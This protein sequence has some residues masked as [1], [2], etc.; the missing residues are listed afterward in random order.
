MRGKVSVKKVTK[1]TKFV[2][3]FG[4][5]RK[6]KLDKK[7]D[8]LWFFSIIFC[9]GIAI[10]SAVSVENLNFIPL[11]LNFRFLPAMTTKNAFFLFSISGEV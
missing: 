5:L 2:T 6:K 1:V 8:S 9:W 11:I 7:G 4:R 3:K 10:R